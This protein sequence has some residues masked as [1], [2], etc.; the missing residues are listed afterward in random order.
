[1]LLNIFSP[2]ILE[3]SLYF[4]CF[5]QTRTKKKL[6]DQHFRDNYMNL[7]KPNFTEFNKKN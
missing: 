1:M 6:L 7:W 2:E 5:I 4:N 3:T